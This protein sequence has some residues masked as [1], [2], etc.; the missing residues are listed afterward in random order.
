MQD[1][2]PLKALYDEPN[3]P[4]G[5]VCE[6]DDAR[7][8]ANVVKGIQDR[9]IV[10]GAAFGLLRRCACLVPWSTPRRAWICR[11]RQT[12]ARLSAERVRYLEAAL[13]GGR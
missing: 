11:D 5:K 3:G 4:I 1:S 2:R 6:V 9:I 10:A 12:V 7:N 8:D 13:W